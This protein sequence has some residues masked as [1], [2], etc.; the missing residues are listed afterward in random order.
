MPARTIDEVIAQ[1]DEVIARS[2]RERSRLGYFALL[3]RNVTVKVKEGIQAGLFEDGARMERLDVIFA[4]RYLDAYECYR[5]RAATSRCWLATFRAADSWFPIVLQHL[6]LGM[7]AH[8]NLDLA[9]A[10][11]EVAPGAQI[12]SLKTD[13]ERINNILGAMI[14]DVQDRLARVSYYMTIVDRFGGRTDEAVMNFSINRAREASWRMAVRL[15][16]LTPDEREREIQEIDGRVA[17]LARVIQYP[18][19]SLRTANILVR[20]SEG[21]DLARIYDIL[22]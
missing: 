12:E 2:R 18:G 19:L 14:G 1:L 20:F 13:F 9:V 21:R 5:R 4:N 6:L 16:Q 15:A 3:Y 8:I 10:A 22:Q 7:N 11:A 17:L